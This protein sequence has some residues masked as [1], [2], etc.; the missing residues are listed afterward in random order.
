MIETELFQMN[1]EN[2]FFQ[3]FFCISRLIVTSSLTF[4][5]H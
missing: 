5:I 1:I 3:E 4:L 2:N